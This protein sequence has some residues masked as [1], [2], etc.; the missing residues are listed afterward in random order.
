MAVANGQRDLAGRQQGRLPFA[1][2][3]KPP[4]CAE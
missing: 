3:D 2:I 1:E 4:V